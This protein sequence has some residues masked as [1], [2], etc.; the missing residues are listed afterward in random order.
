MALLTKQSAGCASFTSRSVLVLLVFGAPM[1]GLQGVGGLG[2]SL[3]TDPLLS[4]AV[5]GVQGTNPQ[6]Q[7]GGA[8]CGS[9]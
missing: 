9:H 5:S 1:S 7:A 3:H 4:V 6:G 2:H 8:L